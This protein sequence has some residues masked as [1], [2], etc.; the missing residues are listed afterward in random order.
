VS[1]F[2]KTT[3]ALSVVLASASLMAPQAKAQAAPAGPEASSVLE[4]VIVTARKRS[5]RLQDVPQSIQAFS[6][7]QIERMNLTDMDD[8]ASLSSSIIFDK[9][10][11][12]EASTIAIRGLSPTRGRANAAVLVDGIDVT[13]EALGSA[14]GGMLISTR[15]LDVE[16]IEVVR[17]PQ[18]VEYGRSAFAGAIQYVTKD[19]SAE[20]EGSAG[21]EVGSH[22]R[23]D[24]RFALSGPIVD[25]ILGFRATANRW[26]ED[27]YYREQ[28]KGSLLG[29][30]EGVGV[31]GTL[32]FTPTSALSFKA[33]AE[34]FDDEYRPEAQYLLRSN[35]GVLNETN[36]AA[37]AAAVAAGVIGSGGYAIYSGEMPDG[38]SL[39]RPRHRPDPLTGRPFKGG[40]RQVF[41][42]SLVSGYEADF[43]QFTA[44][45]GYTHGDNHNRQDHDQD[46]ILTGPEG[47]QIDVSSRGNINEGTTNVEQFS[48]EL[49]FASAWDFPVQLTVGGLYWKE[50]SQRLS[51][52]M[53]V[54]CAT[55]AACP[56]G[57]VN[58][59]RAVISTPDP[60]LRHIEH[61]SAY[62]G[63]EWAITDTLKISAEARY[64][65]EEESI[66]GSNCGLGT[67]RFGVVCGDPFA[68]SSRV[69][70][71]F[72]PTTVLGDG[73]TMAA[74]YAKPI[75]IESSD[76]FITPRFI[77]EWKPKTDAMIYASA[78]KG[79]KPGGTSTLAVG[80]WLDSDHDGDTDELKYGAE[81]LW[82]YELGGKFDWFDGAVRT[83]IAVFHQDY[84]DKQVVST[85]STPSGYPV[86]IIENAGAAVVRGVEFEGQ[87]AVTSNLRLG[88]GY[89]FLDTEYTDFYVYTDTRSGI[90]NGGMCE[91]AVIDGKKLC[92]T[93]LSGNQLEKAP[94][95]SL[96][97]SFAYSAPLP[98]LDGLEWL[99]EGDTT[100]QSERLVDQSNAR[101]LKAYSLTNLRVGV[102]ADQWEL[103]GYVDNLFD[104]DT[105][106][107]ADVK[108]G[109]VDRVLFTP[110]LTTSTQAVLVTLPDP[111]RFGVR[112]NYRF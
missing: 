67:N 68:T 101:M 82:S 6:S 74:A 65:K 49:R 95:H 105:I 21:L 61:L 93:D 48:Q 34:Y 79:V 84:T 89:T 90:I 2:L 109:D 73:K 71:V 28:A 27:G 69:P 55:P 98:G 76:D 7:E 96:V 41:R 63:L 14:G 25:G 57:V 38:D 1:R 59:T 29:G 88:V 11:N 107:S 20:P 50:N 37:L 8:V 39:G 43:G 99:V 77:L 64:A 16:R 42:A 24:V 62:A 36:N 72:G 23:S 70:P 26:H 44:W 53:T 13:S 19:P 33:R 9:A 104:D 40:D 112:L 10:A 45:T 12:P 92:G 106:R 5:E 60:T 75:T 56:T 58:Q 17:G 22:G 83:N 46:A 103:I 4:D 15:L 3:T 32:L 97:A 30:G 102:T 78:A 85:K 110:P 100:Y 80:A 81:T 108:T 66:T 91:M 52:V 94:K 87:W 31:S 18:S 35:S 111:R 47:D 54:S 51:Q 86:G